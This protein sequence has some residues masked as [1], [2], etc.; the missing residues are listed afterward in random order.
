MWQWLLD[1]PW[2]A[3]LFMLM[4]RHSG[5]LLLMVNK[6]V[7]PSSSNHRHGSS[8]L[9][10]SQLHQFSHNN[11]T[12]DMLLIREAMVDMEVMQHM[13]LLNNRHHPLSSRQHMVAMG[14]A[15]H[16]RYFLFALA[17]GHAVSW[18]RKMFSV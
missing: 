12:R 4:A 15:T 10:S 14:R 9:H 2:L 16:L 1:L 8:P 6:L 7:M 11:G 3:H 13:A 17:I 5:V 18:V